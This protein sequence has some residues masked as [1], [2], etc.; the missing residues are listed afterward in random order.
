MKTGAR[1][2]AREFFA[3][4][5]RGLSAAAGAVVFVA[6]FVAG[7]PVAVARGLVVGFVRGARVGW[8]RGRW[9]K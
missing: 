2:S 9:G 5:L 1:P 3:G 8:A 6:I 4:L 7:L